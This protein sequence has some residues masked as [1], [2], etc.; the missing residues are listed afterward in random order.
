MVQ[1]MQLAVEQINALAPDAGSAAAGKKL[2]DKRHWQNLGQSPLAVWGECQGSALYQVKVDV[3]AFA[4]NCTC[5]SR[6]L[7]CKHV[8]GLLLLTA[9]SAS[10]VVAGEAPEWVTAWLNKRAATARTKEAKQQDMAARP[11]DAAAQ[12]KRAE[13][14]HATVSEGVEQLDLWLC[15]LIRGGLA[16]LEV[17]PPSFW[18]DQ[19]RRLIDAQAKGLATRVKRIGEIPGSAGNWP[20]KLL[21]EIGRM[22][23]LTHAFRGLEKLDADLQSDVRQLIGWTIDKDDLAAKGD[24]I[25][26]EWLVLG[27]TVDEEDRMRVQRS[28]LLG[29]KTRRSALVLHFAAGPGAPGFSD[30]IPPATAF[31]GELIYYPSAA[32]Q[33]AMIHARRQDLGAIKRPPPATTVNEH[34]RIAAEALAR[35]PWHEL[36]LAVLKNVRIAPREKDSWLVIDERGDALPLARS[37]HWT[38]LA[39][40]GGHAADIAGVWDGEALL[41]QGLFVDDQYRWIGG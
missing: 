21:G 37:P 36:L 34:L 27:Q 28:W 24:K 7:P 35:Q 14:R 22:A 41:P 6:K 40:A 13:R 12:A 29:R 30:S 1:R 32:P 23:L 3:A 33:R 39:L 11:V 10:D 20:R 8:L 26:D 18:E 9:Q 19:A 16:E 31:E 17:K 25:A 5:P 38:L 2:A 15:D 4:Y